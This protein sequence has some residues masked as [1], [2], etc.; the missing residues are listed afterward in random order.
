MGT[1]GTREDVAARQRFAA[2]APEQG[3]ERERVFASLHERMFGSADPVSVGRFVVLSKIGA[4]AMGTVFAAYDPLLDRKVALKVLGAKLRTDAGDR[5]ARALARLR[6]PNVVAV[7]E[8]GSHRGERFIAMDLVDGVTLRAWLQTPRSWR[9]VLD[10]LAE[11][12][13]ALVAAHEAGIVHRDFKPDNVLVEHG[14]ARV[15][16]FG[17]SRPGTMVT[18]ETTPSSDGGGAIETDLVVGTPAYMAPEAFAGEADEATDQYSFCA[19][20]YE[21]LFGV[22]PFAGTTSEELRAEALAQRVQRPSARAR[23]PGWLRRAVVRGLAVDPAQRWPSITALLQTLARRRRRPLALAVAAAALGGTIAGALVVSASSQPLDR[24]T[25][26]ATRLDE[27]WNEQTKTRIAEAFASTG[28]AY[29]GDSWQHAGEVLERWAG[30]WKQQHHDACVATYEQGVQSEAMFDARMQ[31]LDRRLDELASLAEALGEPDRRMVTRAVAASAALAPLEPCADVERLRRDAPAVAAP[32]ELL[33]RLAR[34]QT[35]RRTGHYAEA[36]PDARALAADAEAHADIAATASFVCA[37]LEERVG[38]LEAASASARASIRRADAAGDDRARAEAQVLLVSILGQRHQFELAFEWAELASATL[39]RLGD[40]VRLRATLLAYEGYALHTAGRFEPALARRREVLEL[41]IEQNDELDPLVADAHASVAAT[42]EAMGELREAREHLA[43]AL[44]VRRRVLGELHPDVARAHSQLGSVLSNLGEIDAA[45][46]EL[47][48][49]ID[50]GVTVLGSDDAGLG[51]SYVN[52]G[53]ALAQG[54]N[55][56]AAIPAFERGIAILERARGPDDAEVANA[57]SNFARLL[58]YMPMPH[59]VRAI[60]LLQRARAIEVAKLGPDHADLVFTDNN[61]AV[62]YLSSGKL[63][64]AAESAESAVRIATAA[65]GPSHVMVATSLSTAG[66]IHRARH[67]PQ[68]AVRAYDEALAIL[69]REESRPALRG[70]VRYHL[71][72]AWADAGEV[73]RAL[74]LAKIAR[75]EFVADGTDQAEWLRELDAWAAGLVSA[76]ERAR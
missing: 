35:A 69:A 41:R 11:A 2:L 45:V 72:R 46:S 59:P 23:V 39:G 34:A 75:E 13:D 18:L 74:E 10:V 32:A 28:L 29:A 42:L 20:M 76:G 47:Q 3:I 70:E 67:D 27:L 66:D 43:L 26:K 17:L 5:E 4:G 50:I 33:A 71:A 16:D 58:A 14:H 22:R 24:C 52:L 15:V 36:L 54:R 55:P 12:G 68:A 56:P 53:S 64:A 48:L 6:H 21:A 61:L 1:Q 44:E 63:E 31:C 9:H 40:P 19:T 57:V 51:R 73:A 38:E 30:D 7:H 8:V 37:A 49:A 62:A 25:P 60:E 65:F